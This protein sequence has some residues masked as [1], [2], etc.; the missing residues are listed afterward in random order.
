RTSSSV[1]LTVDTGPGVDVDAVIGAT[2]R[3]IDALWYD[4]LMPF[5]SNLRLGRRAPRRQTAVLVD[6]DPSWPDQARRLI[7][8]LRFAVER[9][10]RADHI[11]STSVP[12]LPAKQLLDIQILVASLGDAL[13][14]A[15]AARRAGFV[16]ARG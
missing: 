1:H 3:E 2:A 11:G 5:E 9:M 12:R 8:R 10:L 6:P 15:E 16:R 7:D 14:V 13:H 4:R